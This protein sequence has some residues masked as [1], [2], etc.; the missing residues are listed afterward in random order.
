MKIYKDKELK[1]EVTTL[2][3]G[4][5]LAGESRQ[6]EFYLLNDSEA[7]LQSLS[8]KISHLEIK[9]LETPKE[10]SQKETGKIIIEWSPAITLKAPL[11][12]KLEIDGFELYK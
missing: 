3:F 6:Y 4:I 11:K 8:F 7:I 5:V 2:D 10:L 12:A 9:I 1:N